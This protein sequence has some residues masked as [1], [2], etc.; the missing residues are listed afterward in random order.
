ME[1]NY[2]VYQVFS[3]S[4]DHKLHVDNVETFEEARELYFDKD[5]FMLLGVDAP[6]AFYVIYA[7]PYG[8]ALIS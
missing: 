6:T 8:M 5:G 4:E 1:T 2:A 3:E 7:K